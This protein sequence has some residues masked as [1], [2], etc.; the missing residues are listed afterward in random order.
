MVDAAQ[1][2]DVVAILTRAPSAGGKTRLFRELGRACDPSLLEALLLDTLDGARDP[3]FDLVLSVAPASG[4]DEVAQLAP[5]VAVMAQPGGDLGVR[6]S[7]TMRMLFANGARRVALI[8]SDLPEITAAP[9]AAAFALLRRNPG[10]LVLGPANDGG[11]YLVAAARLPSV[12]EGVAW[13][14][15][16]VLRDTRVLA[17]RD[18]F[19]V[20]LGGPLSD[21]DTAADLSRAGRSPTARRTTEWV[22]T[23]LPEKRQ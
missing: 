8:G 4:C 13:G 7:G 3:G 19:A 16:S 15:S 14:S 2:P 22:R 5:G 17:E 21:V 23:H 6:M 1:Q 12:F 18:G 11:Y 10:A 9:I 20:H